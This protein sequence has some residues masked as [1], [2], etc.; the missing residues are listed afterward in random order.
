VA[1]ISAR[2]A[3]EFWGQED[4]LGSS[5]ERV[6]GADD[7]SLA[8]LPGLLSKPKG[9]QIIG[10]VTDVISGLRHFDAP[11][12]YLPLATSAA[13]RLVV[14]AHDDPRAIA[15]VVRDALESLDPT[16]RAR[17]AF[18]SDGLKRERE[19]PRI[20][21]ALA[22]MVGSI[23]LGLAIIGLFGVTAFAVEQRT[24]EVSVRRALGASN[25]QLMR[26]L[27][28]ES[29]KP[30]AVGLTFGLLLALLGGRVVQ[31]VLY[32][33]NSR[34]PIAIVAAVTILLAA[35]AAA[36]ALPARRA[37]RVDPAQLLKMG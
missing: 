16:I 2:L 25:A 21:A 19:R 33:V 6:W 18:P 7:A 28:N 11:T 37:T 34:D 36:V 31:G 22:V 13:T 15:P 23:A 20:L 3:R 17:A 5:L 10:V 35:A 14:R 30:V 26:M 24:H 29:L 4:P 9:T 27:L 32:G 8:R 12:I 1:V